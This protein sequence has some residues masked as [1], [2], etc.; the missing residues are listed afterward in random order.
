MKRQPSNGFN[1]EKL[2]FLG[3]AALLASSVYYLLTSQPAQLTPG[4][5]VTSMAQPG[6]ADP[7]KPSPREADVLYY[8]DDGRFYD[9]VTHQP[10]DRKRK[11]PFQPLDDWKQGLLNPAVAKNDPTKKNGVLAPPPI[12]PPPPPPPSA[13]KVEE[14]AKE[15]KVFD[16]NDVVAKVDFSAVVTM[17]G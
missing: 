14:K 5:M 13:P 11:N 15:E 4:T 17:N 10:V 16:P 6:P 12:A 3:T 1:K 7:E 2:I 8:L 9:R